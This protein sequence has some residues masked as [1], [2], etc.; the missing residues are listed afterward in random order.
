MASRDI[1]T[2]E[3]IGRWQ[4][5]HRGIVRP[6]N[7]IGRWQTQVLRDSQTG[8]LYWPLSVQ[9]RKGSRSSKAS[10]GQH[11]SKSPT[12]RHNGSVDWDHERQHQYNLLAWFG[13]GSAVP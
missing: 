10:M 1:Q 11:Q 7:S 9:Y 6:V 5:R 12:G 3:S 8:G 2:V 13:R 4:R